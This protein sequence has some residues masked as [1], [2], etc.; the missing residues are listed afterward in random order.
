MH[1][2]EKVRFVEDVRQAVHAACL[3]AYVQGLQL[4]ARK[5]EKEEWGVRLETCMRLWRAGCIIASEGLGEIIED[6]ARMH[7]KRMYARDGKEADQ[8]QSDKA[9]APQIPSSSVI[10]AH[11]ALA[12]ALSAD[13]PS[14]RRI[15]LWAL[16]RDACVPTLG[17]SLE[18]VKYVGASVLPTMF[19]EAQL[20]WFGAH[21]F[22]RWDSQVKN[23]G[24]EVKKGS[25]HY[26][27][28]AA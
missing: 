14:L 12:R 3:A 24:G 13:L 8:Q 21:R 22:E 28:R 9:S 15:V 11:P 1:G 17:A 4:V 2:E 10:P 20:D 5:S 6:V 18:W 16:E 27:W 25:E 26:E 19:M 7:D 23:T